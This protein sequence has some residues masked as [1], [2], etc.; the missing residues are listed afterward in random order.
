[1]TYWEGREGEGCVYLYVHYNKKKISRISTVQTGFFLQ[2]GGVGG[3]GGMG[4]GWGEKSLIICRGF[5]GFFF[6]SPLILLLYYVTQRR[7]WQQFSALGERVGKRSKPDT[8]NR[9]Q[10]E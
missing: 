2:I 9:C 1:M 8:I 5:G 6:A 3:M 4:M 7:G 10:S